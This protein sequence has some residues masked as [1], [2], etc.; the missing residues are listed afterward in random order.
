MVVLFDRLTPEICR[1]ANRTCLWKEQDALANASA[2]CRSA[3]EPCALTALCP[4]FLI[5][6]MKQQKCPLTG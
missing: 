3:G 6:K 1:F 5:H 4:D 2:G